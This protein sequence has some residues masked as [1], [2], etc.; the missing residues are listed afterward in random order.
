MRSG[1]ALAFLLLASPLAAQQPAPVTAATP[2]PDASQAQ[3]PTEPRK[4][5]AEEVA[6]AARLSLK[7]PG[8]VERCVAPKGNEIVVCAQDPNALRVPSDTDLGRN[9]NDGVPRAPDVFGIPGGGMINVKGC[10]V[11]PCPRKMPP[12]IDLKGIPEAPPGS[13][14]ARYKDDADARARAA[15][16]P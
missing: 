13:D 2:T 3:G 11:P 5:T 9:T 14:A 4:A 6:E 7:A 1:L 10:F 12:I 8:T 16:A 15:A